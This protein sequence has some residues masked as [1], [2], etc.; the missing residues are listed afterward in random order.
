MFKSISDFFARVFHNDVAID[1]GTMNTLCYVRGQGIVLNEPTVI[2]VNPQT[3]EV[4]AVGNEAKEML[5]VSTGNLLAI[6]PMRH[7]AMSDPGVTAKLLEQFLRKVSSPLCMMRPRVMVAVPSGISELVRQAVHDTFK[8]AG[9]R[10]VRLVEE[11]LAAAI[12]AG[13][14]VDSPEGCMIV[15]IGGGTT[16]IAVVA[17]GNIVH[18]NSVNYAGDAMDNA[19]VNHMK[20]VHSLSIGELVSE[21]IKIQ[22]GSAVPF[23]DMKEEEKTMEVSGSM[24]KSHGNN[25]PG[26]VVINSEEIRSALLEPIGKISEGIQKTLAA[27]KPSLAGNLTVYG[28]T[29]T[30]G[31]S[32]LPGLDILLR[33]QFGIPVHRIDTPTKSVTLGLGK[34]MERTDIFAAP[35]APPVGVN[36]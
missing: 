14:P 27:C 30:G 4:I 16:E 19:I 18:C 13:L 23:K 29:I 9:A 32:Q 21:R 6:R 11:P 17:L 26:S 33:R 10:E 22:L 15:D 8:S 20:E 35:Q 1:L 2:T 12:G 28:M 31:S 5:G 7:G 36:V 25:L 34:M 3:H 24:M